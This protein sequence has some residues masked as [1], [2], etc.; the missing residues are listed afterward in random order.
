M[1]IPDGLL[2]ELSEMMCASWLGIWPAIFNS[3]ALT[4]KR[5]LNKNFL[6]LMGR[7]AI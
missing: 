1:F 7:K 5:Y 3:M 4:N 6:A 2:R